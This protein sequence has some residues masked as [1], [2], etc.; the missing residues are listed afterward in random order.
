MGSLSPSGLALLAGDLSVS[1]LDV[2]SLRF[3]VLFGSSHLIYIHYY[4]LPL[5][6][7]PYLFLL[8]LWAVLGL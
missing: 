1:L 7:F 2:S 6:A 3:I 4:W 5:F 8:P